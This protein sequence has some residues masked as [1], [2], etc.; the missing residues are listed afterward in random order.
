MNSNSRDIG[1]DHQE[2]QGQKGKYKKMY[3]IKAKV[4]LM[5]LEAVMS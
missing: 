5:R 1:G 3:E 4:E 2:G